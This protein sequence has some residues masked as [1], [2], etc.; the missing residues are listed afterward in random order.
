MARPKLKLMVEGPLRKQVAQ[1][2]KESKDFR[3]RE[4]LQAVKL[5]MS[6]QYSFDEI[7]EA[8]GRSRSVIQIWIDRFEAEGI[9]GLLVRKK[10]PG[11]ESPIASAKVLAQLRRGL[12][13]GEWR[14]AAQIAAWLQKEHHISRAAQ[15]MYYWLGK[16]GGALK[17]PRPVHI[18]KDVQATEGFKEHLLEKLRALEVPKG[19]ELKVWICDESRYGLHTI[20][21]RCWSL[22]GIR[23]V[24][25]HQIKYEWSYIYGA[26]DCVSGGAEFLY[27]PTVN[28]DWSAAFLELLGASNTNCEHIVIWDQAGFHQRPGNPGL[29]KNVHLLLLPPYS[30]E[31]NPVEKLWDL[32]KDRICNQV[33]PT[34]D[35]IEKVI[36]P[37]L[38]PFWE[39]A[40]KIRSL[41]GQ[42]WLHTQVNTS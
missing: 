10:A 13:K 26:L 8:I 30:P 22:R 28:L 14:T 37:V 23:P 4:R 40:Q 7:S 42:G 20:G 1:R 33:F 12:E 34:L 15:T 36:T 35:A 27:T 3:D 5:A 41:I 16:L 6:G 24:R 17:V 29:P 19:R 11:K 18:K 39:D 2:Y 32:V 38:R 21:R 31:L 25:P 9:E